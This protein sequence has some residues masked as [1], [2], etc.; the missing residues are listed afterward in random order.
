MPNFD[1]YY[2]WL[3][4]PPKDQPPN[5]Y[6]LLGLELFESDLDVISDASEQR[7]A[8]VRNYQLGQH[9]ALS[10]SILNELAAARVCL[11]NPAEES[12]IRPAA[13]AKLTPKSPPAAP[14]SESPVDVIPDLGFTPTYKQH[15]KPTPRW[16]PWVFPIIGGVVAVVLLVLVANKAGMSRKLPRLQLPHSLPRLSRR[17][18]RRRPRLT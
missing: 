12:G 16:M 7:M 10:Q 2:K 4:I 8:H 17:R 9:M 5:H 15:K 18:C 11:L 14:P 6:R 13:S 1:P 3:A